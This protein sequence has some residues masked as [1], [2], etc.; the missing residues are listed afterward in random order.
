MRSWALAAVAAVVVLSGVLGAVFVPISDAPG[1][2][3]AATFYLDES[4]TTVSNPNAPELTIDAAARHA[5]WDHTRRPDGGPCCDGGKW[6]VTHDWLVPE[7]LTTGEGSAVTLALVVS[8]VDPEQ[9][10]YMQMSMR[11]PDSNQALGVQYPDQ[12]GARET[13]HFPISA[14]Y[15]SANE[16]TI[17]IQVVS[18]EITYHYKRAAAPPGCPGS[19]SAR[20]AAL[21]EVRVTAV[22]PGVEFH[23]AGMPDGKWCPVTVDTVLKQGDEISLDPDGE[24]TLAFADNSTVTLRGFPTQLK[25]ASFF[26]EGG[27]VRTEILLKMGEVAAQVNK[28][29]ATKSDFRIKTPTDVSSVRGTKFVVFYDP[30]SKTSLTSVKEGVVRVDPKKAGLRTVAVRA[31]KEVEVGRGSMSNVVGIGKA[32]ARN[33][34][35]RREALARVR[36]VIARGNDPCGSTTPRRGAFGVKPAEEGWAISVKLIGEHR[37][38]SK[39]R[40]AGRK[41]KPLNALAKQLAKRCA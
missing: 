38:T 31:G 13:F 10:L 26:T 34:N 16:L 37:G 4:L 8:D 23:K 35:N 40:V 33:G 11:A 3:T 19:N 9:R 20:A 2:D 29:E 21:N 1:A 36:A 41:V 27:V 7:S 24:V 5:V 12:Q 15:A 39:W 22:K 25:I 32:G 28:S 17:T 6:T 30:G 18:A 14:G